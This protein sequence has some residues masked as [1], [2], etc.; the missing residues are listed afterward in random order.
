MPFETSTVSDLK[1]LSSAKNFNEER[2]LG[3]IQ[4]ELSGG[5]ASKCCCINNK[6][7]FSENYWWRLLG[8]HMYILVSLLSE[9]QISM[10]CKFC[11]LKNDKG[12]RD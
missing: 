1:I 8:I 12:N 7:T 4:H 9:W 11:S 2:F 10:T 3:E 5:P 6:Q